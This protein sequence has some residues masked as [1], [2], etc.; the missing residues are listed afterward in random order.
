MRKHA[1]VMS[2]YMIILLFIIM[3]YMALQMTTAS[4]VKEPYTYSDLVRDIKD[5]T[6]KKVEISKSAEVSNAGNVRAYFESTVVN[7]RTEQR[8]ENIEVLWMDSFAEL[9]ETASVENGLQVITKQ[10]PKTS[11]LLEILPFALVMMV[12]V[13]LMFIVMQQVQG[14]GSGGSKVMNF[15]KSRAKLT[16]DDKKKVTFQNVAGLDEEKA[17]LQELVDFLKSP[18]KYVDIGARIPKGVLLVGPPGTGKT[19]LAKAVAGE[20]GVPFFSISGSDFVEMFVGVG[21]SRVRDLFEQAKKNSPDRK[22]VV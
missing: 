22:S 21:A 14:G 10:I 16:V 18:K 4:N 17:E 6:I 3:I 20:A 1:R 9:A 15:G 8:V 11:V 7:G 5:G 12:L 13:F 2:I 19:L